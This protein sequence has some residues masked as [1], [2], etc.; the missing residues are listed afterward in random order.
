M[1]KLIPNY[2]EVLFNTARI[3][4]SV[5]E[6]ILAYLLANNFFHCRF[7]NKRLDFIPFVALATAMIVMIEWGGVTGILRYVIECAVLLLLLFGI[8]SDSPRRK[9][10][11]WL[12]FIVMLT[13]AEIAAS[14]FSAMLARRVSVAPDE[15]YLLLAR[16]GLS[17]LIMILAA[18][19]VGLLFK[20]DSRPT[21]SIPL[22][23]VLLSVP[24]VTMLTIS[25]YQYYIVNY[26]ENKRISTYIFLSCIGLVYINVVVFMLFGRL[27]KQMALKRETDMLSSLLSE[28]TDSISRMETLYNRTRTFRHD[29]KNHILVMNMLAEQGK[30]DELKNYLR[31]MSGVIDESDYVRISGISAVDAILNE[32]MYE[33][34][35]QDITTGFDVVNMDKNTVAPLDLCIILSNALDNAIEAN[36]RVPDKNDR[37]IKLKIHGNETF[38]V[39][40]VTN[41]MAEKPKR[42]ANGS[43]VTLKE[44]SDAHGFGLKSIENTALK[45]NGEMIA[46]PEDG[47]FTLVVRLNCAPAQS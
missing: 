30:Y 7:K 47:V 43:F 37:Y 32:K 22:W 15:S 18:T 3:L 20:S 38:S 35:A 28:Q 42:L 25:V 2:P 17:N 23:I 6:I 9:L 44:D 24:A 29:I 5:V 21:A 40:S 34:Q 1:S 39:I 11:V 36:M 46:K 8:Y 41:P 27:Q 12:S 19:L 10:L 16:S 31:E 26:P 14:L 13:V 4:S 33:A 45:Y